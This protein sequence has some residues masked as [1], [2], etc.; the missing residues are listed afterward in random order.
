VWAN[1]HLLV[2]FGGVVY[3]ISLPTSVEHP[4]FFIPPFLPYN[5]VTMKL[6]SALITWTCPVMTP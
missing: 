2:G 1:G 3:A 6:P 4:A 5:F